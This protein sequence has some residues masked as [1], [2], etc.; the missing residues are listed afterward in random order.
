MI[1][2]HSYAHNLTR[3][4]IIAWKNSDSVLNGIRTRALCDTGAVLYQLILLN[5]KNNVLILCRWV[6]PMLWRFLFQS[7]S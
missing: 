4:E 5:V 2:N 3:C 1:D 7:V 6:L